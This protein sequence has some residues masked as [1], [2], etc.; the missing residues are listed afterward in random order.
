MVLMGNIS[1]V[2]NADRDCLINLGDPI[3]FFRLFRHI[4]F[5]KNG[6]RHLGGS[7]KACHSAIFP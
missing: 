4:P 7:A 1:V 6:H 3:H 2:M 5:E